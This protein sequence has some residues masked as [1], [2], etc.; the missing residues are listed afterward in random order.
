MSRILNDRYI[1]ECCVSE[2]VAGKTANLFTLLLSG[3]LTGNISFWRF[4]CMPRISMVSSLGVKP[5]LTFV[6]DD[7]EETRRL[8]V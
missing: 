3:V 4:S 8:K 5:S 2:S 1:A 6:L 7:W